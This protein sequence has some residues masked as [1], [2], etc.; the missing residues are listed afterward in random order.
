MQEFHY[1]KEWFGHDESDPDLII[2]AMN[3]QE[4]DLKQYITNLF[5]LHCR[6]GG[7]ILPVPTAGALRSGDDP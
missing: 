3:E 4:L 5:I 7:Y 1:C 6:S 2:L